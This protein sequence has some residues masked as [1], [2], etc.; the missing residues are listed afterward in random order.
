MAVQAR[1]PSGRT[2]FVWCDSAAQPPTLVLKWEDGRK[3]SHYDQILT[4]LSSN[5]A[6][7]ENALFRMRRQLDYNA[8]TAAKLS[9]GATTG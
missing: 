8:K 7:R 4:I 9:D 2:F 3:V 6:D 5:A 1:E